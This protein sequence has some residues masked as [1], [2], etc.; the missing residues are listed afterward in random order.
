MDLLEIIK[1]IKKGG[2]AAEQASLNLM[3]PMDLGNDGLVNLNENDHMG[4]K[5]IKKFLLKN[6][7]FNSNEDYEDII[8]NSI[9]Q[10]YASI[11]KLEIRSD[12]EV[13]GWFWTLVRNEA[14]QF[15]LKEQKAQGDKKKSE[16]LI[17]KIS[18]TKNINTLIKEYEEKIKKSDRKKIDDLLK[19]QDELDLLYE[20]KGR[21][22]EAKENMQEESIDGPENI[23]SVIQ[24][25]VKKVFEK[26]SKDFKKQVDV[27]RAKEIEGKSIPEIIGE[28]FYDE[29]EDDK[30]DIPMLKIFT[31]N[32]PFLSLKMNRLYKKVKVFLSNTRKDIEPYLKPCWED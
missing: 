1:N 4:Y 18:K 7:Q 17:S 24:D 6:Y 26:L 15:S 27:Y 28:Y 2:R 10:L 11:N 5:Q 3:P 19:L 16:A 30:K 22:I 20:K 12:A 9:S 29:I 32:S 13:L 31:K 25:C 14:G 21:T 8:F 23:S